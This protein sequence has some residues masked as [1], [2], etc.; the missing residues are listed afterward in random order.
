MNTYRCVAIRISVLPCR[1]LIEIIRRSQQ[2]Q[3]NGFETNIAVALVQVFTDTD[4]MVTPLC[5]GLPM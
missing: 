1:T 3:H 5:N 4:T 2:W